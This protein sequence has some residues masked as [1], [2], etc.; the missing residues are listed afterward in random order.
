MLFY[1]PPTLLRFMQPQITKLTNRVTFVYVFP[2]YT[3]EGRKS[4]ELVDG[5]FFYP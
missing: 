4:Y 5:G 1:A 3:V 2:F